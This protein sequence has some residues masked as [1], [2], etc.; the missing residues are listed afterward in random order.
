ML[1]KGSEK[2]YPGKGSGKGKDKG[3]G[4]DDDDSVNIDSDDD[5]SRE[6]ALYALTLD[7][8]FAGWSN[9]VR[10][11]HVQALQAKAASA[12]AQQAG[13]STD[14]TVI[15]IEPSTREKEKDND[16]QKEIVPT[17]G[18]CLRLLKALEDPI[19]AKVMPRK[20]LKPHPPLEDPLQAAVKRQ[21]D[22]ASGCGYCCEHLPCCRLHRLSGAI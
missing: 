2:Q 21:R 19:Q 14:E 20:K 16:K 10:K 13:S 17:M 11:Q 1:G 18:S 3:K 15:K 8:L 7:A 6:R 4:G 9:Y 22:D 5:M 12:R